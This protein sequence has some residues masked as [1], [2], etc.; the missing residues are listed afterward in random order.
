M[1]ESSSHNPSSP[2]ITPKEEPVTLDKPKSPN[3]FLPA[4]Q[5]EFSFDEIS[6]TTNNEAAL[7]YPS[8]SNSEY[9]EIVSNFIS[10]CCLNKA[11]TRA[12]TQNKET[13]C[14]FWYTAKT[15]DDS[16]IWVST[17]TGGIK[18]DISINT[19]RNDLRAH[20]LPHLSGKTGGMDQ[21]S[22]K[23]AT[24]LYCLANMVKVDYAKLIWEDIIHK[25]NKKIREKVI[26]YPRFISIL[27]EY[28]M[29]EYD[30]EELT[31]NPTQLVATS[32]EA[33][34]EEGAHPQLNSGHDASADATTEAD[35]GNFTPND[36][37]P[38]QQDQTKSTRDGLKTAHA[39]SGTKEESR[40]DEIS[41]KI[42]L[43]DLSDLLKDTSYAFLT[44]DSLQDEPIIVSD[45]SEKEEVEKDDT[46]AT[47]L[48]TSITHLP[49]LKPS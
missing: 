43:E 33:T 3:P 1:K 15:L 21:I 19:F 31:I 14:E 6:L 17:P 8:Y 27:L 10:K 11:F 41:K 48:D 35:P 23:N 13:L 18:G 42:K 30:N 49:S 20:Y 12:P 24:I 16:K 47:S 2:K 28:M 40:D 4:D 32:L 46:H 38:A 36:S 39:N 25:L 5:V 37:I 22:N 44:P 45:E 26:P 29:P 7:L 34:S 9:F